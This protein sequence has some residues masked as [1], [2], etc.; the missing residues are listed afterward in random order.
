MD[1][2]PVVLHAQHAIGAKR[3]RDR[4][5]RAV[6]QRVLDEVAAED[7]EGVGVEVG[8]D[9]PVGQRRHDPPGAG[10]PHEIGKDDPRRDPAG[11]PHGR[12]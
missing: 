8:Q 1:D 6:A 11:R 2:R 7:A 5:C 3:D 9:R 4:P 10:K 12:A